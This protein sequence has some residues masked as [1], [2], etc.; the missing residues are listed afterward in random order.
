MND[1]QKIDYRHLEIKDVLKPEYRH[2]LRLLYWPIYIIAFIVMERFVKGTYTPIHCFIDDM[3][4]FCEYFIVF[5][6][7]WFVFWVGMMAYCLVFEVAT[8]KKM[9][10]YFILTFTCSLIIYAVFPNCQELR[11]SVFPRDNT[12]TFITQVIY[13]IDTNTNVCPSMHVIG[14]AGVIFAAFESKRFSSTGRKIV[15]AITGVLIC[16]STLFVK[17]HSVVDFAAAIPLCFLGYMLCFHQW[18][19]KKR[20]DNQVCAVES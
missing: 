18:K 10:W 7:L 8:Y 1:A 16:I 13:W 17:Q 6:L 15:F 2:L 12:L 20:P 4:P 9:M 19:R 14:A 3:I 11:P 5:Y